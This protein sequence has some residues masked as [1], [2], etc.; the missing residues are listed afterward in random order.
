MQIIG[1]QDLSTLVVTDLA[2]PEDLWESAEMAAGRKDFIIQRA[3]VEKKRS[4]PLM[5]GSTERKEIAVIKER[6]KGYWGHRH[7]DRS[8]FEMGF[9]EV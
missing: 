8:P 1:W 3:C 4:K 5:A 6:K 7:L 9:V 2:K